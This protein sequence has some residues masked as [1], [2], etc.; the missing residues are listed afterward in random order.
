MILDKRSQH[1]ASLLQRIPQNPGVYQY[2]N[3]EGEIIYVGKAKNLHR[4][5]NSYFQKDHQSS[6]TRQLVAHIADIRYVVVDSEQD[7]FLLENNLIKKYQPHYNI[8]LK[9]GKSYPSICITREPYPR[10]FKTR[11]INKKWGDYYGPYSFGNTVDLMIE[12]IHKLFPIRSCNMPMTAEQI[13][14]GKFKVCLKYHLK[15]CCGICEQKVNKE[16]YATWVTQARKIIRGD[17]HEISRQIEDEMYR[18]SAE[19]KFEEAQREKEKLEL[20]RQFCSKTIITNSSAGDVDVFGYDEQDDNVYISMLHVHNGSIVQGQTIEYKKRLDEAREEIL[21]MGM[22][23]LREQLGSTTRE[24]IVPFIPDGFDETLHVY[25]ALNGD[26]KKLLDL[27][28]QNVRQY[29]LDRIKQADKLNPDQRA[30]RILSELQRMLNLPTLPALIDSFD[31][32][33]INGTNAVAGCVVF[34][35][36][37][38]SKQDYKRFEIKTVEGADDYASMR[39]V[40]RRRYSRV[41]EEGGKL[42]DL[43]IADGGIGQ[44]HAIRE[45][46][47]DQLGLRI[48][49]AGLKKNDKHRTQTL[50]FGFPPQEVQMPVTSEVFRLLTQIQDEVHRFAIS[51]HKQK[52]SKAQIKS[53]LDDIQGVGPATKQKI[54]QH[55]GSVK[56]AASA[57]LGEWTDL[58]GTKRG[59]MLYEHFQAKI[60]L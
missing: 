57:D 40:V 51:Y 44:M 19:M 55:F 22:M 1:I 18:L 10:I 48:P 21:A 34:R 47:E 11:T 8:L 35:M 13:E 24:V 6:K 23:E 31:N 46:V 14:R 39:E 28:M 32:S 53:Q 41:V 54:L 20:L 15:T 7:A 30:V 58:L 59:S 26:K 60:T 56:R 42:P 27:A 50:L 52:R 2:F 5:V 37:K 16:Q 36:A 4:R 12:L 17:G 29:K 49:I 43:I 25:I 38:P 33:N 9:D 45:A 3:A